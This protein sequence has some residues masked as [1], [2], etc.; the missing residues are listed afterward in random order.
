LAILQESNPLAA[1]M[2]PTAAQTSSILPSSM[3]VAE[4]VAADDTG[5][6]GLSFPE[7]RRIRDK[8]HLRS[9]PSNRVSVAGGDLRIPITSASR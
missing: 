7:P 1:N 6:S 2:A 8:Q 9:W 4:Q 5:K 3:P